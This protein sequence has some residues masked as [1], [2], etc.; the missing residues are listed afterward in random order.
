MYRISIYLI[1]LDNVSRLIVVVSPEIRDFILRYVYRMKEIKVTTS[2]IFAPKNYLY[3]GSIKEAAFFLLL[4][5]IV[6]KS[7]VRKMLMTGFKL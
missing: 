3:F 1:A 6:Q 7:F 4:D 2:S 5:F